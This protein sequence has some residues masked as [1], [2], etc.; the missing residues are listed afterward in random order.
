MIEIVTPKIGGVTLSDDSK[1]KGDQKLGGGPSVLYDAVAI[2]ASEEEA[3]K[4]KT[5][6]PFRDFVA[7]AYAHK[8]FIGYSP[9]VAA[10]ISAF[11]MEDDLDADE[12]LVRLE[13]MKDCKSFITACRKLRNWS[14]M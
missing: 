12:A 1:R 4:L 8:K 13:H 3:K 11:T 6:P 14:R 5:M 9:E 2:I 10:L 7:D